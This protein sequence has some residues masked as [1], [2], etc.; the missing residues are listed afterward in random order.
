[1][2][3]S[4]YEALIKSIMVEKR[5]ILKVDLPESYNSKMNKT[6]KSRKKRDAL[7][8]IIIAVLDEKI[9]LPDTILKYK[10][11]TKNA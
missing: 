7:R 11:N 10:K 9:I 4:I 3:L 5:V 6:F 1:M 2:I 8:S